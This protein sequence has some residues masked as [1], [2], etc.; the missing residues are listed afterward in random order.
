MKQFFLLIFVT[1]SFSAFAQYSTTLR[2]EMAYG[3][4]ASGPDTMKVYAQSN[5]SSEDVWLGAVHWGIKVNSQTVDVSPAGPAI[6][7][8]DLEAVIQAGV[9]REAK[10]ETYTDVDGG[11]T[12]INQATVDG[13]IYDYRADFTTS[14]GFGIILAGG[15]YFVLPASPAVESHLLDFVFERAIPTTQ[16]RVI[17]EASDDINLNFLRNAISNIP[18]VLGTPP[19][20]SSDPFDVL[21]ISTDLPIE[22]LDF[23]AYQVGEAVVQLEWTTTQE[24]NNAEFQIERSTD[25][26]FFQQIAAMDGAG[27]TDARK[28]YDYLDLSV[29]GNRVYYRLRQVDFDGSFTYSPIREVRLGDQFAPRFEV[30]PNPATEYVNVEAAVSSD[31][32]FDVRLMDMTG[33]VVLEKRDVVFGENQLRLDVSRLTPESYVLEVVDIESDLSHSE[34]IIVKE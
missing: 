2:Y 34:V 9:F 16:V 7:N 8:D 26:R 25:G 15:P 33:R 32:T 12:A 5:N 1:L 17:L 31:K 13:V 14:P 6:I 21:P 3:P 24:V 29:P 28:D 18:D 27:T 19:S 11:G 20:I 4:D 10:Y 30:Y 22:L 23:E